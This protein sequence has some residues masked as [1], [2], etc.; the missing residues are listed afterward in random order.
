VRELAERG[1]ANLHG[2]ERDGEY[3]YLVWDFVPG[4]PLSDWGARKLPYRDLLFVA[5]E[6]VLTIESLHGA[7]IV[8]G[9]VKLGNVIFDRDESHV[10]VTHVS[11][12]LHQEPQRDADAIVQVLSLALET[13]KDRESA[14][15]S[16]LQQARASRANLRQLSNLLANVPEPGKSRTQRG[17]LS[18]RKPARGIAKRALWAAA[19]A[20]ILGIA[21]S[22]AASIY[23]RSA[24]DPYRHLGGK[25]AATTQPPTSASTTPSPT[26]A[27]AQ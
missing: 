2:V 18:A 4:V 5:R 8:H 21:A 7:G 12:M 25:N 13:K 1:V 9:A 10:R 15:G 6:L 17:D 16:A 26:T 3:V 14:L 11:P 27:Q 22:I 24:S 19:I 23:V 20:L